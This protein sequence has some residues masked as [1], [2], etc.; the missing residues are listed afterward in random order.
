MLS[1]MDF[2][3]VTDDTLQLCQRRTLEQA[4]GDH[5][6][7]CA[8][9]FPDHEGDNEQQPD[10]QLTQNIRTSPRMR[11]AAGLKGDQTAALS[12]S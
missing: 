11:V 4:S 5:W 2:T 3:Q 8:L 6:M 9:P 10:D 12:A 7:L 1:A